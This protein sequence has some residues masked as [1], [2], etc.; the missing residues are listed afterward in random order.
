[1]A[2][3]GVTTVEVKSGYGLDPDGE[4]KQLR[5]IAR[6]RADASLPSVVATY[7]ALHA[8][9]ESARSNRDHYV[10]RAS[11]SMVQE[12]AQQ[13]LAQF[14]DAYVD[15]NAFTVDEA[16]LVCEAAT[17]AG[18]GVRLHV[19]QFADVG[20]AQLCA[21]VG[22]RSADHLENVDASG[23]DALARAGVAA[24]LLPVA[25]FTLGQAPPPVHE[26]REAGVP[27]VV[28]SDAN[29][30]TAPTES[31][32]LA[33]SLAVRMYGLSPAEAILGATRNAA[34]S[35]GLA[36]H[37]VSRPR[38][39]L[40]AG[41]RADVVVWDL[42]HEHAILQPWGAPKTHAVFRKGVQIAGSRAS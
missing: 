7:L 41:A 27:L 30:G 3:L 6:A 34:V 20:G 29:P 16:R 1:M 5:A 13:K 12:V 32:P 28:A 21:E 35:L 15:Q 11:T 38:G 2:E 23:I 18:L 17:R 39:A 40:V 33:M 31:L 19:G 9:P 26:L 10:L 4:R 42:P 22:A 14:V 36:G 8:L 37:G 24:T 25:S